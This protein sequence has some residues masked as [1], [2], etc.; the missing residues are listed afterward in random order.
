[1]PTHHPKGREPEQ[2]LFETLQVIVQWLEVIA[3]GL[4]CVFLL[5]GLLKANS[6]DPYWVILAVLVGGVFC[7][8]MC[9][10]GYRKLRGLG[11]GE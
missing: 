8:W 6:N 5:W 7:G 11:D 9:M 1:M 3:W 4:G 10:R 2:G